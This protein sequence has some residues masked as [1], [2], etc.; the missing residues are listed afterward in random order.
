M[1]TCGLWS[2]TLSGLGCS[3]WAVDACRPARV[4]Q[5]DWRGKTQIPVEMVEYGRT[6]SVLAFAKPF[7]VSFDPV[8]ANWPCHRIRFLLRTGRQAFLRQ[9][10]PCFLCCR[11]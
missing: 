10:L 5:S 2:V 4:W 3:L 11:C 9:S 7:I 8:L 1:W 6:D